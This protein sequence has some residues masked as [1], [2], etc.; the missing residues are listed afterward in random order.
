VKYRRKLEFVEA[1]QFTRLGI[2]DVKAFM[3]QTPY[4]YS[5]ERCINGKAYFCINL[6]AQCWLTAQEWDWIVLT[7]EGDYLTMDSTDFN[8]AFELDLI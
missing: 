2:E 3:G 5:A 8:N 7:K 1:I 4:R 6:Y